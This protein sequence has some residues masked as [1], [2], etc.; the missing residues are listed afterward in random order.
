MTGR[1]NQPVAYD[2]QSFNLTAAGTNFATREVLISSKYIGV[3]NATFPNDV[4]ISFNGAR[5]ISL[6]IGMQVY[7]GDFPKLWI[8]N[9]NAAAN[10]V[11]MYLGNDEL[12]DNR[13]SFDPNGTPLPVVIIGTPSFNLGQ[14]G[15]VAFAQGIRSAAQSLSIV[16]NNGPGEQFKVKPMAD[17]DTSSSTA[18]ATGV[19][20]AGTNAQN[21]KALPASIQGVWAGNLTAAWKFLRLYEAGGVPVPGVTVPSIVVPIPPNGFAQVTPAVPWYWYNGLGISITGAA[22]LLDATAVAAND[23]VWSIDYI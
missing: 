13:L 1:P 5:F 14:V 7:S 11:D 23:V 6:P 12:R 3:L 9:R 17:L 21:I 16:Q 18:K 8:R 15:G 2:T 19:S 20:A 4:E 22:P 10:S